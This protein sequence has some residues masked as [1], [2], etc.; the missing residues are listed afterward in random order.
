MSQANVRNYYALADQIDRTEGAKA[1]F[2]YHQMFTEIS[3]MYGFTLEQTVAGFSALSPNTDYISNLRSLVSC[4][5]GLNAGTADNDIVVSTYKHGRARALKYLRGEVDFLDVTKGLKTRAFYQNLLDP[6][7]N[8]RVTVD[9]HMICVWR[10][11][12][13]NMKALTIG[14]KEYRLIESEIIRLAREINLLGHQLQAILWLTRK[15]VKQIKIEPRNLNFDLFL[16][17]SNMWETYMDPSKIEPYGTKKV[18]SQ[19]SGSISSSST[20]PLPFQ[21]Q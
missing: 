4:M 8:D 1:Y 3:Q 14:K 6:L 7:K 13:A 10:G 17:G 20:L 12:D 18:S 15:R 19:I 16:D 9:G 2:R 11:I 21:D 5:V